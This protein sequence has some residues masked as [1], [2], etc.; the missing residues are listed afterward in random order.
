MT[1]KMLLIY[2]KENIPCLNLIHKT[3]K[4]KKKIYHILTLIC[5]I[6]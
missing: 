1:Y 4:K 5:A 3:G 2:E 6:F